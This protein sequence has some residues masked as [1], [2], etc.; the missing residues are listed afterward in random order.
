MGPVQDHCGFAEGYRYQNWVAESRCHVLP[1]GSNPR[2]SLVAKRSRSP[3]GVPCTKPSS[4]Q[5]AGRPFF[6]GPPP[7]FFFNF[8]ERGGGRSRRFFF[9]FFFFFFWEARGRRRF[10][11]RRPERGKPPRLFSSRL[12]FRR[13]SEGRCGSCFG[14]PLWGTG[15]GFTLRHGLLLGCRVG[16]WSEVSG[17]AEFIMSSLC[18]VVLLGFFLS[19]WDCFGALVPITLLMASFFFV[20]LFSVAP[21]VFFAFLFSPFLYIDG[22][23]GQ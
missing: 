22:A 8:F 6:A 20:C 21:A 17:M 1:A 23:C 13:G 18:F 4:P 5:N 2:Q 10:F 15:G 3:D 16:V 9:F 14:R 19:D 12:A 7:L 11:P